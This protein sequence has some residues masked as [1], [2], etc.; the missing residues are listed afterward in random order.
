MT[1]NKAAVC[2]VPDGRGNVGGGYVNCTR[3][4]RDY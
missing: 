3:N 2:L 4:L 1:Y